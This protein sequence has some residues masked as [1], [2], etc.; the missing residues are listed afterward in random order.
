MDL[1]FKGQFVLQLKWCN[2]NNLFEGGNAEKITCAKFHEAV[3]F[4]KQ[5]KKKR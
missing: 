4:V 3:Y 2:L 5:N 1:S